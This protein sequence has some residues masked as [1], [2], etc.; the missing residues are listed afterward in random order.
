M[1]GLEIGRTKCQ[2]SLRATPNKFKK[3]LRSEALSKRKNWTTL[4]ET[5]RN[6]NCGE[7]LCKSTQLARTLFLS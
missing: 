7:F 4:V 3:K 5:L 2:A 1:K 6:F